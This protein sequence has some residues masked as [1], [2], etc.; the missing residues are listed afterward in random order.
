MIKKLK[1]FVYRLVII[2]NLPL[3]FIQAQRKN[4]LMLVLI[5]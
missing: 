2:Y 3:L 4:V 5:I 1:E